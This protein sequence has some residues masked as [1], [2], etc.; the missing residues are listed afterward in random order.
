MSAV[1]LNEYAESQKRCAQRAL[2]A[3][4]RLDS[5]LGSHYSDRRRHVRR[6][7]R[8]I[9]TVRLAA[10]AGS[11]ARDVTVWT[12]EISESGMSFICPDQITDEWALIR[13]EVSPGSPVWFVA[14]IIR[15]RE[16]PSEEFWEHGIA[17]RGRVAE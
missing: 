8:S 7:F 10:T 13:L 16:V 6:T 15:R 17:F 5:R 11:E 3:L 1:T 2:D 9:A 12:R 14:D 4:D